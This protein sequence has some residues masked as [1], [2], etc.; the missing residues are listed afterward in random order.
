MEAD[1]V[2]VLILEGQIRVMKYFIT[3][4]QR[5]CADKKRAK[6]LLTSKTKDLPLNSPPPRS[7]HS[8][9]PTQPNAPLTLWLVPLFSYL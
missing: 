7:S 4:R 8:H 5:V 1:A 3:Q 6:I 2:N 9:S